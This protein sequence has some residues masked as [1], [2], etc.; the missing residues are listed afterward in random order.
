MRKK[1]T[2]TNSGTNSSKLDG[3]SSIAEGLQHVLANTMA[4]SLLTRSLYWNLTDEEL[5]SFR[6]ELLVQW[7]ELD[8][9]L[10]SIAERVRVLGESAVGDFEEVENCL[11]SASTLAQSG[12]YDD[13]V[14]FLMEAHMVVVDSLEATNCVAEELSDS[15][16]VALLDQRISAH[17]HHRRVLASEPWS[18]GSSG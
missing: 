15:M 7:R 4:L 17:R 16:T 5:T 10:E 2:P 11:R 18:I 13:V 3:R 14:K 9:S 6:T 1:A 8:A 12:R